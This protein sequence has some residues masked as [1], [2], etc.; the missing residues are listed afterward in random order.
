MIYNTNSIQDKYESKQDPQRIE[1]YDEQMK[2]YYATRSS[3]I[4]Q[5]GWSEQIATMLAKEARPHMLSFLNSKGN[6][7]ITL[8]TDNGERFD[9]RLITLTYKEVTNKLY[10]LRLCHL[11]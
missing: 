10:F 2:E 9:T 8:G 3:N 6:Q 11:T 5:Q 4:K 1:T 7:V